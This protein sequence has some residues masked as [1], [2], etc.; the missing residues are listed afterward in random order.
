MDKSLTQKRLS[1]V[2]TGDGA[3][4]VDPAT[5]GAQQGWVSL[6]DWT[7]M[8]ENEIDSST[9]TVGGTWGEMEQLEKEI[10]EQSESVVLGEPKPKPFSFGINLGD[11]RELAPPTLPAGRP[12]LARQA[13]FNFGSPP[14][15]RES[16]LD[17]PDFVTRMDP[18]KQFTSSIRE[19]IEQHI[20]TDLQTSD[21]KEEEDSAIVS[22]W[23][24]NVVE[25]LPPS[26]DAA[27]GWADSGEE[28]TLEDL[29]SLLDEMRRPSLLQMLLGWLPCQRW[30]I[31]ESSSGSTDTVVS[32][33]GR[34]DSEF[35]EYETEDWVEVDAEEWD[36]D[37]DKEYWQ[38][39]DTNED[40]LGLFF[41]IDDDAPYDSMDWINDEEIMRPSSVSSPD[42]ASWERRPCHHLQRGKDH[43]G[44]QGDRHHHHRQWEARAQPDGRDFDNPF[45][46]LPGTRLTYQ[47]PAPVAAAGGAAAARTR[48]L[49]SL[50]GLATGLAGVVA[51]LA[52]RARARRGELAEWERERYTMLHEPL[53]PG[54]AVEEEEEEEEGA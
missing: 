42:M 24:I 14:F 33:F 54:G 1:F 44:F 27:Q 51:A 10:F 13:P 9:Q 26:E 18:W 39:P 40:D 36:V 48:R 12:L 49:L 3:R 47:R 32:W 11:D 2:K 6:K 41:D 7:V 43:M 4:L 46:G 45:V 50:M 34:T 52:L 22:F 37:T 28:L 5:A 31:S 23:T 19:R 53:A 30:Q 8:P 29:M 25:S 15:M 20:Q 35:P 16:R 38:S 17:R 21:T